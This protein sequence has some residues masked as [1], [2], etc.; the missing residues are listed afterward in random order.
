MKNGIT[1]GVGFKNSK[2]DYHSGFLFLSQKQYTYTYMSGR[3]P[4]KKLTEKNR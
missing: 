1:V 2:A 4:V 3:S